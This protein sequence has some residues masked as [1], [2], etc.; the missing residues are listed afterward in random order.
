MLNLRI[1]DGAAQD[2]KPLPSG[3]GSLPEDEVSSG[4]FWFSY[5]NTLH[6]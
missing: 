6:F 2:Y 4:I 1:A 3:P 5:N